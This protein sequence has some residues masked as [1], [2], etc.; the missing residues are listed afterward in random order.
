VPRLFSGH[1]PDG[2]RAASG[3]HEHVFLA[4]DDRNKDRFI[5]R[6]IVAAP[7]ACDRLAKPERG[8]R[9]I[10]EEIVCRLEELRA[11]NLGVIT[12]GPPLPLASD[13]ALIG[14]ACVW[15]S[16]TPYLATRHAG[17]RKDPRAALVQDLTT[18][19]IRRGLPRP[20]VE[21]LK[22]SAVSNGTGLTTLARLRFAPAVRGPLLL[23][24]DSHGGG[25]LFAAIKEDGVAV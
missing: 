4:A 18:E 22:F 7:W 6:L 9:Q 16:C 23:G 3:R 10:F 13:D 17:R 24:R 20:E 5:D 15:E 11:G 25:G 19:C 14:S 2:G 1:E 12:L 21:I 8:A